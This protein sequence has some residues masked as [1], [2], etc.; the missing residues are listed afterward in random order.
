MKTI[1]PNILLAVTNM[2]ET[3]GWRINED[4]FISQNLFTRFCERLKMFNEEQQ[5]FIITLTENFT[6]IELFEYLE[7]FYDSLLI[8]LDG[9]IR[10]KTKIFV[11]PLLK[12]YL[13]INVK[14]NGIMNDEIKISNAKTKSANFLHY[15]FE[16]D[17]WTWIT[18][19]FIHGNTIKKLEKEFKNDDSVLFLIDDYVGSGKTAYDACQ[20]F[21]SLDFNGQKIKLENIKVI[22]IAAQINGIIKIKE[23]LG[24]DVIA[25]I[26]LKKG[27]KDSK[28]SIGIEKSY[29]LMNAIESKLKVEDE[30]KYGYAQTEALITFLNKTPNNTFPVYWLNTKSKIAPFPRTKKI[31]SNG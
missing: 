30:Y 12:P 6:R 7:K 24:I 31:R 2:F 16:S 15:M 25:N 11:Y 19:K 21:L 23:E 17:D 22:C 28:L 14:E 20:E 4:S 3:K 27:I 5:E 8:G 18:D 29:E 1:S 9:I 10:N 26:N 13:K